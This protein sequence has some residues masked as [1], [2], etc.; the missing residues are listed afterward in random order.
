MLPCNYINW[1]GGEST[2]DILKPEPILY[3]NWSKLPFFSMEYFLTLVIVK[4]YR[5]CAMAYADSFSPRTPRFE[6]VFPC[7]YHPTTALHT[8]LSYENW[9]TGPLMAAAKRHS[10]T[11]MDMNDDDKVIHEEWLT[12]LLLCLLQILMDHSVKK[13]LFLN[14]KYHTVFLLHNFMSPPCPPFPPEHTVNI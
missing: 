3:R 13:I 6:L 8:H 5:S 2:G 4:S 1:G 10:L 7:Q 12:N 9:T 11:P 14:L